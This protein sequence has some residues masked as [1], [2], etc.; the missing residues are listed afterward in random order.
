MNIVSHNVGQASDA[1]PTQTA[2]ESRTEFLNHFNL[3]QGFTFSNNEIC[4]STEYY[5]VPIEYEF[6][7][8]E[9]DIFNHFVNSIVGRSYPKTLDGANSFLTDCIK[10]YIGV[11]I[12]V[13]LGD[14]YEVEEQVLSE[15]I[16]EYH[17]PKIELS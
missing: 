3:P 17:K 8:V 11:E 14:D 15:D 9:E 2:T 1:K 7:I 5:G 4:D 10:N 16:V 13:W 6:R 12:D